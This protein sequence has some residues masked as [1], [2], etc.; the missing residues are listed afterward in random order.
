M[1]E[2]DRLLKLA[3]SG[4]G[5]QQVYEHRRRAFQVGIEQRFGA[6]PK[7]AADQTR[8]ALLFFQRAADVA[9]QPSA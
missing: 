9:V 4:L 2:K 1:S 5:P 8:E 6:L 3:N 7:R